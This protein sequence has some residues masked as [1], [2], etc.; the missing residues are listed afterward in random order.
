MA[1]QCGQ[2]RSCL[3]YITSVS[4]GFI[5][6]SLQDLHLG[7]SGTVCDYAARSG[8]WLDGE[9]LWGPDRGDARTLESEPAAPHRS[10]R[11]RAGSRAF[12][13]GRRPLVRMGE[14]GAGG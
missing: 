13:R 14:A 11:Y 4:I 12:A 9:I 7:N 2:L 1:P 3:D 10:H 6:I 5:C 8:A